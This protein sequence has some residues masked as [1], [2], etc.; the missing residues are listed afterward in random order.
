MPKKTTMS[1]PVVL[2][3]DSSSDEIVASPSKKPKRVPRK[4][5]ADSSDAGEAAQKPKAVEEGAKK[6]KATVKKGRPA[7]KKDMN[8]YRVI[9][10]AAVSPNMKKTVGNFFDIAEVRSGIYIIS[11]VRKKDG[12]QTEPYVRPLK[13]V[14]EKG[15]TDLENG[16]TGSDEAGATNFLGVTMMCPLRN[17]DGTPKTQ[18]PSVDYHW[19]CY[20]CV[21]SPTDPVNDKAARM[22]CLNR[23]VD[24]VQNMVQEGKFDYRITFEAGTDM[25]CA[26]GPLP[27]NS[28][29]CDVD[30][31]R[32]FYTLYPVQRRDLIPDLLNSQQMDDFFYDVDNTDAKSL[33]RQ[34]IE[35]HL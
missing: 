27:V 25:T 19:M 7:A 24:Y 2:D 30:A 23:F 21:R 14:V 4:A 8:Q 17:F 34:E 10:P 32:L 16:A 31:A 13:I 22:E 15:L 5:A 29:I 11:P 18:K 9:A 35:K 1:K 3:D 33:V 26:A 12:V 20:V 6:P 28:V